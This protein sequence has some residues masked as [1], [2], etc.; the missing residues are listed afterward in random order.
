MR[1]QFPRTATVLV[2]VVTMLSAPACSAGSST[3]GTSTGSGDTN[4]AL[5]VGLVAEPAN[6]DFTK[7]D[8]AAIPQA[9]LYNVYEGLVKLD[10][11]GEIIPSLATSWKVSTDRL[12]YTFDLVE[13]AKFT[14][15]QAFSA[16]DAAFSISRV[17][18][19][20][21]IS[22]KKSMDVV[23]EAKAISPTQ[24]QVTLSEPSN[25]WLF[26]MTTRVGAMFSKSG[27]AK[28]ATDPIGTGPYTLKKW[29]RGDSISLQHNESYWGKKPFFQTVN[30]KYFKDP[31]ALNNA[32]LTGTINVIGTVQ[33]PESLTQF[34]SNPKYQVI[35]GT[36]NGE[37]VLSFNNGKAPFTDKR[38]RQAVRH[39]I[40]HK[41]LVDTCWAGR[42]KLIGSMVA[43]TDPWNEDLTG[44]YPHD[45]AKAKALLTA[46]GKSGVTLRLRVPNLPYAVSCGQVVKSQLEEAGFKVQLDQL[47]FPAAWL[48][49]V[50]TNADY[51]MSIVAHVEPRDMGTVFGNPDY[52][53][54]YDNPAFQQALAAADK[55][56]QAQQIQEMK[57]A[58]RLLSEDAAADWLFLLP[59]LMVADKGI[60]GLP[61]NAIAESFDLSP[62]A[63]S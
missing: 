23:K 44:L 4:Q 49:T 26:R 3:T 32:L 36:T 21:T 8:G 46:A 42:G 34:T 12:T 27:V 28:L 15:G 10:N 11:D 47:E 19:D 20:W 25:D 29:N 2:A 16:E 50:F 52:Y 57:A 17:K 41:A 13:G 55:G 6:L 63:R 58:A 30:F 43:P 62:L 9:L 35:E 59:N 56:T 48:T 14:N 5:A 39:A 37:V 54:R 22:L 18:T 53:T 40:D 60:T 51:D 31:T 38:V 1:H 45:L 24:L 33:A 61:K 7:T